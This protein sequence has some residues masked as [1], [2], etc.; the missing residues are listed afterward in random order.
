MAN[1]GVGFA[2]ERYSDPITS[3]LSS[4]SLSRFLGMAWTRFTRTNGVSAA[5]NLYTFVPFAKGWRISRSRGDAERRRRA[6]RSMDSFL[7]T[8]ALCERALG[9]VAH[10]RTRPLLTR[11]KGRRMEQIF[12]A[13]RS[14]VL[15]ETPRFSSKR[16]KNLLPRGYRMNNQSENLPYIS[17]IDDR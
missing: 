17:F 2:P 16:V 15:E 6:V 1:R 13:L 4:S 3:C 9:C 5:G 12:A 7:G 11:F 14:L 10:F 8:S